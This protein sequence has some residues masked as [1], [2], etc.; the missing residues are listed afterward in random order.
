MCAMTHTYAGCDVF[1]CVAGFIHI[2]CVMKLLAHNE[3]IIE[4]GHDSFVYGTE[5]IPD[6]THS[7][8]KTDA[9]VGHDS[10]E[11]GTEL[12]PDMTHSCDRTDAY[13]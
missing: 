7:Y 6:M 10:F 13:M 9:Y 12:I 3:A 4:K 2:Q 1:I 11:Y 8:D 5:L